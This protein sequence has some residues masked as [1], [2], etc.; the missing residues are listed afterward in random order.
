MI[1]MSC[2]VCACALRMVSASVPAPLYTGMMTETMGTW[3]TID[4]ALQNWPEALSAKPLN[5]NMCK[6]EQ[7]FQEHAIEIMCC[8][9]T[10]LFNARLIHD[11]GFAVQECL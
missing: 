3:L 10:K 5:A 1:S 7:I 11:A 9:R 8:C 4:L 6:I 2:R